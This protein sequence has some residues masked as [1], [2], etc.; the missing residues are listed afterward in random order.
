MNIITDSD[1]DQMILNNKDLYLIFC[2]ASWCK[3]CSAMGEI[4]K[5]SANSYPFKYSKLDVEENLKISSKFGIRSLPTILVFKDGKFKDQV[6]GA[7][8]KMEFFKFL[9]KIK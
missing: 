3:P 1:F 9:D 2:C 5:N 4:L 7:I 6:S 8:T